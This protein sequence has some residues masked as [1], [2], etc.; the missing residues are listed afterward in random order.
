MAGRGRAPKANA[1]RRNKPP[2]ENKV[3]GAA[4]AGRELPEELNITTAGARRFWDTWCRSPQVE[5]FEETDW[6]ELELT[7]VLVDRFHQGD[8]KL[9][10]EI[11]LRVAKW[12]ATTEDRSRLRMSFDK[13]VEDE[14]PTTQADRK[15]VAMDRYKQAF[16]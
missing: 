13:H 9:A 14:K 6:T 11:R 12:G 5:T 1:V 16:G 2:F 3:S 10:A 7:T 4:Q 8:T 15:V